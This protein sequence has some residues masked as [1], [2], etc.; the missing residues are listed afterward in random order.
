MHA[1]VLDLARDDRPHEDH[2]VVLDGVTGA[3]YQRM[4]EI[5]GDRSAPRIAYAEGRLEMMSPSRDHETLKSLIGR[6]VEVYCLE[7][8]VEFSAYGSWTLEDK[9]VNHGVEPD[10]C[11]VFGD[12]RAA[13]RPDL[14]SEVVWTSGGLG[15]RQISRALGVREVWRWRRGRITVHVLRDGAYEAVERSEALPGL[16]L[17]E[18]QSYLDRPSTSRAIR[19]YRDA[20]RARAGA[21]G[22]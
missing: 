19:D 22:G 8:G 21:G 16:V 4:R 14:A 12:L 10:E 18:L 3:D 1:A 13:P 7:A 17:E 11:Y 6:L 9:A 15:K 2:I 20:L 5:R